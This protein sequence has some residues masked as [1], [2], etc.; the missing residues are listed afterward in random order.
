[1]TTIGLQFNEFQKIVSHFS[2]SPRPGAPPDA[3]AAVFPP[4]L[5]VALEEDRLTASA[6]Y[7]HVVHST[8]IAVLAVIRL[9]IR[10][11]TYMEIAKPAGLYLGFSP[12]FLLVLCWITW[13]LLFQTRKLGCSAWAADTVT[14][15]APTTLQFDIVKAPN[16]TLL[17]PENPALLANIAA[18]PADGSG[19]SLSSVTD[20][21][22]MGDSCL[23]PEHRYL[24]QEKGLL[25]IFAKSNAGYG[26]TYCMDC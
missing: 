17:L 16:S 22:E 8:L 19:G 20:F 18:A 7:A 4:F 24:T 11:C 6:L 5:A 23:L 9:F 14:G 3:A 1:M 2:T 15:K 21:A 12:V 10:W 13:T 25:R 26:T